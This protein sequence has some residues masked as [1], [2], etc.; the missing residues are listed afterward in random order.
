M[1]SKLIAV[2]I[3]IVACGS[4]SQAE[5]D[6]GVSAAAKKYGVSLVADPDMGPGAH[7][8]LGKVKAALNAKGVS[9][10]QVASPRT[11]QGDFTIVLGLSGGSG[12]A[13]RL[14]DRRNIPK[15][16]EPESLLIKRGIRRGKEGLLVS[17][18]D[19]RDL[20]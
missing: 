7:H 11:A 10:E 14:H 2:F 19:D 8:G 16:A 6:S 15:P 4:I 3:L 5:A 20:P 13:A 12:P 18:A 17:G 9:F 1:Q